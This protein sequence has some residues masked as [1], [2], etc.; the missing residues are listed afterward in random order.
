MRVGNVVTMSLPRVPLVPQG[1]LKAD[2]RWLNEE[3]ST[4]FVYFIVCFYRNRRAFIY[5][6][7]P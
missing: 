7:V 1:R 6:N 2:V 4:Y 3:N 5:T